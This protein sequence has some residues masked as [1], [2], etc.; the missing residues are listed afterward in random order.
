MI[1]ADRLEDA[2]AL[3][4]QL[5]NIETFLRGYRGETGWGGRVKLTFGSYECVIDGA[6]KSELTTVVL[7]QRQAC[8]KALVDQGI[9]L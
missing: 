9:Q 4:E 2:I 1:K 5:K 6:L 8:L 7:A 3:R